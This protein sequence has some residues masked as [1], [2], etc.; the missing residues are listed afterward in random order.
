MSPTPTK[1]AA[2]AHHLDH[3]HR[4]PTALRPP[5]R[6]I[7]KNRAPAVRPWR[8]LLRTDRLVLPDAIAD[9][10]AN[11]RGGS[12]NLVE[13]QT[14][15]VLAPELAGTLMTPEEFDAVQEADEDHVYELIHG[16]LVVSPPP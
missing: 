1:E 6:W 11:S 5:R 16:M 9:D 3:P 4:R 7:M 14:P 12:M 10:E 2:H 13:I 8:G 15:A